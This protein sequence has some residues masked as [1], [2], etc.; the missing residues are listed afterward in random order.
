MRTNV[1][2]GAVCLAAILSA[3]A[4][5]SAASLL[6]LVDVGGGSGS[7]GNSVGVPGVATVTTSSGSSG[8]SAS[9]SLLGGGGSTLNADLSGVLGGNSGASVQLPGT[10]GL[11]GSNDPTGGVVGTVNSTVSGVTGNGGL[12]DTLLGAGLLGGGGGAG[13]PGAGGG[14][15]PGVRTAGVA[16]AGGVG[17]LACVNNQE[18]QILNIAARQVYTRRSFA[19]WKRAANIQLIPVRLCAAARRDIARAVGMSPN[20]R[21]MQG[22]LASDPLISASLSRTRYDAANVLAVEKRGS[23]LQVYV[24]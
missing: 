2:L 18:R 11:L 19:E 17:A 24:F 14:G 1:A 3:A 15:V 4:P 21:A 22:A 10:G 5:A 6:G 12:A 16:G 9:G 7:G 8:T 20:I 13:T 23:T